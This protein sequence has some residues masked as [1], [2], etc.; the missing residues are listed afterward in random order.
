M[1]RNFRIASLFLLFVALLNPLPTFAQGQA[2]APA[3]PDAEI[4]AKIRKEGM[5]NSQI[6]RTMHYFTDIY[7]PRL[8]G[9]PNHENSAKWAV[10]QMAEWGFVN[11]H[12]EPWDFG[13]V[14]WL[15]ERATAHVLSPFKESLVV[16]V[17][18]WTPSTNGTVTGQVYQL[19][20]PVVPTEDEFKAFADSQKDKVKGKIVMVGKH[21]ILPV[22][23]NPPA[24]RMDD[25]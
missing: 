8:T 25:A 6:M 12:L 18:G 11:T 20:P 14:G 17:L 7:G 16:E 2:T 4:Q 24:K 23:I 15:N 19:I 10:K 21:Q 9:S 1:L 3:N 5:E 22:V 13:R